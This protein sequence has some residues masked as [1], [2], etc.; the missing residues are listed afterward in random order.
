MSHTAHVHEEALHLENVA[1]TFSSSAGDSI[2]RVYRFLSQPSVNSSHSYTFVA[3]VNPIWQ[4]V[5]KIN[6][7]GKNP[8]HAQVV[9]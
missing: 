4:S 6:R 9:A 7:A 5:E 8:A 2:S 3:I 1:P